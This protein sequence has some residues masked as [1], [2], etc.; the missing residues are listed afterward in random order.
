MPVP[1]FRFPRTGQ[2]FSRRKCSADRSPQ[3]A[4]QVASPRLLQEL[5]LMH[6]DAQDAGLDRPGV[7][8]KYVNFEHIKAIAESYRP[9]ELK[10]RGI[11]PKVMA[12]KGQPELLAPLG[13]EMADLL[14]GM[15]KVVRPENA[16]LLREMAAELTK[17]VEHQD[18]ANV[19]TD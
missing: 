19:G 11:I 6:R 8:T 13:K 15:Q 7:W 9:C 5:N 3:A 16:L 12:A 17:I 1:T 18:Q 4:G 10:L 14:T 2:R